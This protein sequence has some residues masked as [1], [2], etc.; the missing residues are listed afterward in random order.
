M[1]PGTSPSRSDLEKAQRIVSAALEVLGDFGVPETRVARIAVERAANFLAERER[2]RR[3]AEA[4]RRAEEDFRT[5]A[6]ERDW[7]GVADAVL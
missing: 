2:E 5:A 3:L 6:Q 1:E 7:K 4:L